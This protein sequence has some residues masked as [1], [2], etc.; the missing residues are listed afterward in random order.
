[1]EP[2]WGFLADVVVFFHLAYVL[3]AAG[4]EAAILVGA[5]A[6]WRWVRA[7]AFRVVHLTAVLVVALESLGG[8]A[9]PVTV[10]EY[11]LRSM[12]G[13]PPNP[14]ITFIGRLLRTIV[15]RDIPPWILTALYLGFGALVLVTFILV[16]PRRRT[17]AT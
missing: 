8:I 10:L 13:R 12:A 5:V 2:V 3:F 15:P 6:G 1:M 16:P 14:G 17:K 7:M 11:R 4:G 9:C